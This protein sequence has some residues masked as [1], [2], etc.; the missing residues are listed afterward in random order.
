MLEMKIGQNENLA[1]ERDVLDAK[2]SEH[3]QIVLND[4]EIQ[5]RNTK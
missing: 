3:S 2:V 4:N 1:S 5:R